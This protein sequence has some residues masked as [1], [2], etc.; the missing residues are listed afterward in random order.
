[1]LMYQI[2]MLVIHITAQRHIC[3]I[4]RSNGGT[5]KGE[6]FIVSRSSIK[7]MSAIIAPITSIITNFFESSRN[8]RLSNKKLINNVIPIQYGIGFL[9]HSCGY[10]SG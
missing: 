2:L 5:Q 8:A 7:L 4:R 1:M 10:L 3:I 6:I 9:F